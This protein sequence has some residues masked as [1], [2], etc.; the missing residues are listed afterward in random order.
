MGKLF[1]ALGISGS[2]HRVRHV[3]GTRLLRAGVNIR[4]VQKLMRHSSL[5]TTA[6][7][8]A[9]DESEMRSAIET[10]RAS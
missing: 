1:T 5:A 4:V 2:I 6:T 8:T 10:L 7:Y 9:V 3:Y